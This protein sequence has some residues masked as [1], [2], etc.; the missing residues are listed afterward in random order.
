MNE[1]RRETQ[2]HSGINL[3]AI[4]FALFKRKW[5]VILFRAGGHHRRGNCLFFLSACLRVRR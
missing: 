2:Q 5:T 3:S 4:L 1:I